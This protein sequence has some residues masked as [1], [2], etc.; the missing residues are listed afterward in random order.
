MQISTDNDRDTMKYAQHSEGKNLLPWFLIQAKF[1][2]VLIDKHIKYHNYLKSNY[3]FKDYEMLGLH[4]LEHNK[5]TQFILC[6]YYQSFK[7]VGY[8]F[9]TNVD[10]SCKSGFCA[11]R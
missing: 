1:N 11:L 8:N 10:D 9:C 3:K 6:N 5:F 4:I 7:S 2:F